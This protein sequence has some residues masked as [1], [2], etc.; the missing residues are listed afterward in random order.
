MMKEKFE[1]KRVFVNLKYN[2]WIKCL[3]EELEEKKYLIFQDMV[4]HFVNE[5]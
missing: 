4:I 5:Y 2:Y 3:L 1:K